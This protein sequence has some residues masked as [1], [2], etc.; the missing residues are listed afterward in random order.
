[1]Y[2]RQVTNNNVSAK[3]QSADYKL[4]DSKGVAYLLKTH[5]VKSLDQ[6]ISLSITGYNITERKKVFESTEQLNLNLRE[7]AHK[8]SNGFYGS[9]TGKR[10]IFTSR[11]IFV[12][13]S[14][15]QNLPL[16]SRFKEMY[17]MD[18]DGGN[19][20]R[21]TFHKGTVISPAISYD[22]K[23]VLYTL[24]KMTQTRR[25]KRRDTSLYMMDLDTGKSEVIS[26]KKGINSGA[27][28]LPD[29]EHIIMTLSH[30]GNAELFKM[31]L[32]T[33]TLTRITR[34]GSADVDPSISAD[35]TILAF[36]SDRPGKP[37]IYTLDPRGQEQSVKRISFVGQF[38]ATPRFAPSGT[39]IAFSSWL[40]NRFD[41]F[42][43]NADGSGLARLTQDFGSNEDPTYSPDGEFIAFS[44]QR[45]INRKKA[46]QNIYIMDKEGE[47]LGQITKSFGNC[48]TPR[49]SK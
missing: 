35:G 16:K 4:W 31:N 1:M 45:V 33:K 11:I 36:L 43:I 3:N 44:S 32:K 47:I 29:N 15:S 10:S 49:W 24:I 26:N 8:I 37:M 2:K 19:V 28:F 6:K 20:R 23:R 30:V 27:V 41:I 13:D 7:L 38:N 22:G 9:I 5:A 40:D 18:F 14:A 17:I 12:S 42:K 48:I 21:L 39:E 46:V 25:G 34:S